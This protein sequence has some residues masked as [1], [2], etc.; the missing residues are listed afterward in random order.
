MISTQMPDQAMI[1]LQKQAPTLEKP[2]SKEEAK[3]AAQEF[4]TFFLSFFLNQ[5]YSGMEP[6][7][8]TG[9][10]HGEKVF[11]SVL[12]QQYAKEMATKSQT[13]IGDTVLKEMLKLQE[14]AGN[15]G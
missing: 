11:N 12:M 4:E 1:A 15:A 8:L 14:G 2:Q 7:P 3:K 13:G 9:G 10:G 6:N 5:M